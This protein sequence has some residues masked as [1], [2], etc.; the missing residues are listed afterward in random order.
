MRSIVNF[1]YLQL[2]QKATSLHKTQYLAGNTEVTHFV[3]GYIEGL[4]GLTLPPRFHLSKESLSQHLGIP[5]YKKI[6]TVFIYESTIPEILPLLEMHSDWHF[7]ICG[8]IGDSLE[9][10]S[11]IQCIP[12]IP[13]I[14]FGEMVQHADAN[15]IRGEHSF[16]MALQ[17]KKPFLWDIYKE[18]NGAHI[19]KIRE[20][21]ENLGKKI[22][23]T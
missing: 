8:Y 6:C 17:S 5:L 4:G 20:A 16:A 9:K 7:L 14:V 10:Y 22:E 18:S 13:M 11:H 19:E 3:P 23:C 15:I 1:D 12:F 21:E 2:S